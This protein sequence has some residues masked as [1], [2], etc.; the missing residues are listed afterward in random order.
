MLIFVYLFCVASFNYYLLNFYLKYMPGDVYANSIVSSVSE[1]VAHWVTGC[2]V[3]KIGQVNGLFISL[4]LASLSAALLWLCVG[5][6]WI[7]PVP[8]TVLAAK[9]GVSAAFALLYMGTLYFFPSRFL[10]R[11]FGTCNVTSRFVTIL[12]PM[13]AEAPTPIPEL[14]MVSSCLLAAILTRF[15][16]RPSDMPNVGKAEAG[17]ELAAQ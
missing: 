7:D 4:F 16:R 3:Y 9:F 17:I 12:A 8:V 15:L 2:I 11:V 6:E 13:V 10:G 14:T 1:S 5:N